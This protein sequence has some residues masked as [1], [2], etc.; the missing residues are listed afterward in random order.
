MLVQWLEL[1]CWW[2][3]GDFIVMFINLN[4]QAGEEFT[5]IKSESNSF[6]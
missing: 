2:A 6:P 4:I 1:D 3:E 5:Q